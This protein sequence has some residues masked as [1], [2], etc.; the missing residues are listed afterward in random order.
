MVGVCDMYG[1]RGGEKCIRDFE[2]KLESKRLLERPR[3][4]REYNIKICLKGIG[5]SGVDWFDAA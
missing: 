3:N 2:Q 1:G 5:W 4:R